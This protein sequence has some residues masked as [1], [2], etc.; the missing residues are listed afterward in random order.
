MFVQ[1]VSR[2][3]F[4]HAANGQLGGEGA[5]AAELFSGQFVSALQSFG[6]PVKCAG[7]SENLWLPELSAD[8]LVR[9]KSERDREDPAG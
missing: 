2:P 1:G 5:T 8:K 6:S 4:H 7:V 9:Q 3:E